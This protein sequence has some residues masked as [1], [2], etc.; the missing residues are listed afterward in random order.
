[1]EENHLNIKIND[2]M[3]KLIWNSSIK[4]NKS[5][6][7]INLPECISTGIYIINIENENKNIQTLKYLKK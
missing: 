2:M 4:I 5:V 1:M 6:E 3:G 7:K